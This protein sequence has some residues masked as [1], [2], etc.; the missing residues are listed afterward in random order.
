[1]VHGQEGNVLRLNKALYGLCEAHRAWNTKLD[2]TLQ[3]LS[4]KHSDC[5]HYVY[6]HGKESPRLLI[7]VNVDVLI[8]T[9][10]DLSMR[11]RSSSSRCWQV[12]K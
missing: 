2:T 3:Q 10:N 6:K 7:I 9:E 4:F 5:E 1:M 8:I 12:S 11:S